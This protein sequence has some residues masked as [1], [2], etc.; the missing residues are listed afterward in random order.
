MNLTVSVFM[1]VGF[2]VLPMKA[3]EPDYS[4]TAYWSGMCSGLLPLT[5]AVSSNTMNTR[6]RDISAT[7]KILT[8]C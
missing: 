4:D 7:R 5:A 6:V 3:E 2:T 1:T 8:T